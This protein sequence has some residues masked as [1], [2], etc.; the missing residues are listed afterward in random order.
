MEAVE[1]GRRV[2]FEARARRV[3]PGRDD[4]ALAAWNGLMLTAFAEAAAVLA[5]ADYRQLAERKAVTIFR[6]MHDNVTRFPSGFGCLLGAL[7]FYLSTPTDIALVGEQESTEGRAL[8]AEVWRRYLPN[9]VVAPTAEADE[10]AARL[11]P[12]L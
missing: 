12:L 2:L 1:R 11:V 5:R 4:K 8:A 3:K 9:K 6:L 7:D 10:E